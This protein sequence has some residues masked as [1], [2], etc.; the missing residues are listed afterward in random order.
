MNLQE[1]ID[2]VKMHPNDPLHSVMVLFLFF[3]YKETGRLIPRTL[4]D[5]ETGKAA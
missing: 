3:R 4:A 5:Q 1:M 2:K